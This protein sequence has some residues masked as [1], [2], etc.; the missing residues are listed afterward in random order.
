MARYQVRSSASL[1][2]QTPGADG[3]HAACL[4]GWFPADLELAE[5]ET[6]R[7]L[8]VVGES[9]QDFEGIPLEMDLRRLSLFC[10]HDLVN[11]SRLKEVYKICYIGR[12]SLVA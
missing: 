3:A 2:S 5:G 4:G 6:E 11:V 9:R 10:G 8:D 1:S 12:R 7:P